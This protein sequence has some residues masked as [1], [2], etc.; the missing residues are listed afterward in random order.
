MNDGSEYQGDPIP[1]QLTRQ[2]QDVMRALRSRENEKYPLNQWYLGALYAIH[3]HNN[4]DR[5]SQAAHSLREIAEKLPRVVGENAINSY[6]NQEDRRDLAARIADDQQRYP[7][8]WEGKLIDSE[9]GKTIEKA[10]V[11]F[12][13]TQQLSR[14]EQV[15][16]AVM[17]ID[18]LASQLNDRILNS[19]SASFHKIWQRFEKFTHH[20]STPD[21]RE[22][23]DCLEAFERIIL[24]LFAPITAQEQQKMRSILEQ[25]DRTDEDIE[26]MFT[27]IEKKG[28]NYTFFFDQASNPAWIPLLKEK[29]YFGD[30]PKTEQIDGEQRNAPYWWPLLYLLRVSHSAPEAVVGIV[31]ELPEVDNPMINVQILDIAR[32][33]PGIQSTKLKERLLHAGRGKMSF[34]SYGYLNLLVHW[35]SQE[36]TCSA[37]QL[38]SMLVRF[39]SDPQLE[40]NPVPRLQDWQYRRMFENAILP[41]TEKNPDAVARMLIDATEEMIELRRSEKSLSVENREDLSEA[42]C[43]K[44]DEIDDRYEEDS[45]A[46][47]QGLTVACERVFERDPGSIANL[48]ELLRG[49]RWKL[50]KRLRQHLYSK[51]PNEQTKPW[52]QELLVQRTD[53][54]Y[55]THGYEFQLMVKNACECFGE[56]LLGIE[57]RRRIFDSIL[58]GPLQE[59]GLVQWGESIT[60]ERLEWRRRCFHE[61]QLR[62]FTTVLFEEYTDYYEELHDDDNIRISDEDYFPFG[63]MKGGMV[64][65]QS[66]RSPEYLTGLIGQELLDFIN[67]WDDESSF[68]SGT[69]GDGW[70]VEVNIEALA[71]VFKTVF[72]DSILHED[73]RLS[74]WLEHLDGIER[75]IYVET[76]VKAMEEDLKDAKLDRLQESLTVC[77]WVLAHPDEDDATVFRE[78]GQARQAAQWRNSRRA[79]AD[80]VETYLN[81]KPQVSASVMERLENLLDMLCTQPDWPLDNSIP[82]RT[83]RFEPF[84]E[85]IN[86][87]R[88]RALRS[89]VKFGLL[90]KEQSLHADTSI[91]MRVLEK[92]FAPDINCPLTVP[93]YAIL[94]V[95]YGGLLHLDADWT[96]EHEK[97]L[98]PQETVH[99]WHAAFGSLLRFVQCYRPVFETLRAQFEFAIENLP[100][101]KNDKGMLNT[102][103]RQ[104]GEDL[105]IYFLWGLFPLKGGNSLLE[106]FFQKTSHEPEQQ[107]LLFRQIG[108][109]LRDANDIEEGPKE[110]VKEFFEWRLSHG[111]SLEMKEFPFWLEAEIL[112]TE[113]RL[114]TFS[115]TLDVSH[116]D[117]IAIYGITE[118]L[119]D[120]LSDHPEKVVAC[121]AK[122]TDKIG[123]DVHSITNEAAR[124]ILRAGMESSE[125]Y[126][127]SEAKRVHDNLLRRG[128]SALLDLDE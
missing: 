125:E 78:P 123:N 83:D 42:W 32:Q 24:D 13:G 22:F 27:L 5:I 82:V 16:R 49:H 117:E 21:D 116:P 36:E 47:I 15:Q 87:T 108:F 53:Y 128:R 111:N 40:Y 29:G 9:L 46:L 39:E 30:P 44:L 112:E 74:F 110:R 92:R 35:I 97:E 52:I 61:R 23:T 3:N 100:D 20:G 50:F 58:S 103:T 66:P 51:Y 7:A 8:G 113:W 122:L 121:F 102:L 105:F 109:I 79:V 12:K 72:R 56:D 63:H 124:T 96:T 31:L 106:R 43:R 33:L 71:D 57:E 76:M 17:D 88:S 25:S 37:L 2:Q 84:D 93:E 14:K 28:A 94:G 127:R 91:V 118:T 54:Q 70:L 64:L 75:T 65:P 48:D 98:F 81:G 95:Y 19:K 26:L 41:L 89:L 60:D 77:E 120:L 69:S 107:G 104:L 68:E 73:D 86:N 55:A 101:P 119:N 90:L 11:Y 45:N 6:N 34:L 126:V 85:A 1:L 67:Q 80:L 114:D 115:R 18:P 10:V 59:D 4:P 62:P 99:N 38:A